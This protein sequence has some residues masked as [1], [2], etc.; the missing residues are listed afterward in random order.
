MRANDAL[1]IAPAKSWQRL[2]HAKEFFFEDLEEQI[3]L[4]ATAHSPK[5]TGRRANAGL[6]L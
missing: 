5:A 2:Q 4:P 3:V 1:V 6:S